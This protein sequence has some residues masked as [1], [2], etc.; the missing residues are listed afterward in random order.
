MMS[1]EQPFRHRQPTITMDI[2]AAD[3]A[4]EEVAVMAISVDV[5]D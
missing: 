5:V 1:A 3:K 2:H 4:I